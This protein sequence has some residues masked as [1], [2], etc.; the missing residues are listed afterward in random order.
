MDKAATT[1]ILAIFTISFIVNVLPVNV[2]AQPSL[3]V[4]NMDT[5]LNYAT[6]QE[7]IDANETLDGHTI[8]VEEGTY[9][10]YVGIHKSLSLIGVNESNTIIDGNCTMGTVFISANSVKLVGFTIQNSSGN[11]ILIWSSTWSNISHNIIRNCGLH[12]ISGLYKG[13]NNYISH[14]FI[15]GNNESGIF[16]YDEVRNSNVANNTIHSNAVYG[17]RLWKTGNNS[18]SGNSVY[19]SGGPGISLSD[20][21]NNLILANNVS[22][23]RDGISL[24]SSSS[25]LVVGN[26]LFS[27]N[28]YG[29]YQWNSHTTNISRNIVSDNTCGIYFDMMCF[30]NTLSCNS[31]FSN[32]AIGIHIDSSSNNVLSGNSVYSNGEQGINFYMSTNNILSNNS[33]GFNLDSGVKIYGGGYN[34]LASNTISHNVYN[35]ILVNSSSYNIFSGNNV[36]SNVGPG[37]HISLSAG[38]VLMGNNFSDNSKGIYLSFSSGNTVS[39]NNVFSN[40]GD[41][42]KVFLGGNNILSC[43]SVFSNSQYGLIV[44]GSSNNVL[45]GNTAFSNGEDGLCVYGSVNNSLSYNT[46]YSNTHYGI[47]VYVSDGN[48]ICHNIVFS[49]GDTGTKFSVSDDNVISSNIIFDHLEGVRLQLSRGNILIDN[50]VSNNLW[51][52]GVDAAEDNSI[53]HNIFGNNTYGQVFLEPSIIYYNRWDNGAEGNYWSDYKERHPNATEIDGSG[54]WNMPY[55]FGQDNQDNYPLV[56]AWHQ[57]RIFPIIWSETICEVVTVS[58]STIASLT[59]NQTSKQIAFKTTGPSGT[60]GFCDITIPKQLLNS[61]LDQWNISVDGKTVTA[62]IKENATHTF[63]YFNFTHSTKAVTITGTDPID[64]TPPIVDAGPNLIVNEDAI[65]TFDGSKSTDNIGI[66]SYIWTFTDG[67][68]KT[69]TGIYPTYTFEMPGDYII[70]LNVTDLRGNWNTSAIRIT[71]LDITPPMA[72]AG[73]DQIAEEDTPVTLDGSGSIDNVASVIYTWTTMDPTPQTL[74]GM[75]TTYTFITPGTYTVI[76]NVSDAAG[77]WYTDQVTITVLDITTPI[78]YPGEDLIVDEDTPLIFDAFRSSDNVG[79]VTYTWTFVDKASKN[80]SGPNPSYIFATPGKYIVTLNVTDAAGNWDTTTITVTVHAIP[81]WTQLWFWAMVII[82]PTTVGFTYLTVRFMRREGIYERLQ[83]LVRQ[84]VSG[85][86]TKEDF[87]RRLKE[88]VEKSDVDTRVLIKEYLP[89]IKS[90]EQALAYLDS[91]RT[92]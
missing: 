16:L 20:S 7:A 13:S 17:I 63:F 59:F 79:I 41:G 54:I 83:K 74:T 18:L 56:E 42:V 19:S 77:N 35:G 91:K 58:N 70:T 71:V 76:L 4:H 53:F 9:Y 30:K 89:I 38:S 26:T 2:V 14:N 15:F 21:S 55:V 78:A 45:S 75:T 90:H 11:G 22:N 50:N 47:F 85:K 62:R 5:G 6:I 48:L 37:I 52:I 87:E 57:T 65:V 86:L 81:I 29:I 61:P 33:V 34:D 92:K 24:W 36:H 80:L 66:T 32:N 10:E 84:Q 43:N 73:P 88:L 51:G 39:D 27:N 40:M 8:L 67:T 1:S 28:E 68:P 82:L 49:N 60:P 64:D 46:V 72:D 12:G 23:N 69:I 44:D 3:P 25:N 31:I